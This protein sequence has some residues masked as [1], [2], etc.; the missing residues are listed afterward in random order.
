MYFIIIFVFI[1][2]VAVFMFCFVLFSTLSFC[3]YCWAFSSSDHQFAFWGGSRDQSCQSYSVITF[4]FSSL[5]NWVWFLYIHG[6]FWYRTY[7]T[8][9]S[10]LGFMQWM[11]VKDPLFI[12][13][14]YLTGFIPTQWCPEQF[15][16]HHWFHPRKPK[17]NAEEPEKG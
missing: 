6:Q 11:S 15:L 9:C 5:V 7:R 17:L 16:L 2:A 13:T 12:T 4:Y 3:F 14:I 1:L 10:G 8:N